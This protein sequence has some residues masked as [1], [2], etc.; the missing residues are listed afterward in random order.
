MRQEGILADSKDISAYLLDAGNSERKSQMLLERFAKLEQYVLSHIPEESITENCMA[1]P[2]APS[3]SVSDA[4]LYSHSTAKRL[5]SSR[6]SKRLMVDSKS[7]WR[8]ITRLRAASSLDEFYKLKIQQVHIVGEYANLMVED[9]DAA[10]Q[11]VQDY[12][13]VREIRLRASALR[14][15]TSTGALLQRLQAEC[16]RGRRK[17][18]GC[19]TLFC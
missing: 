10:L 17:V 14:F 9:Y 8:L 18:T 3:F 19:L 2:G 6:F 13:Q 4:N 16:R 11:Y 1:W 7:V 15:S 12:F 5:I